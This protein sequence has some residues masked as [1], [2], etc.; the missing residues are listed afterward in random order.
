MQLVEQHVAVQRISV[1]VVAGAVFQQ[2][3]AFHAEPGRGSATLARVIG[4]GS[5]LG[6]DAICATL[7]RIGHQ[8]LELARLVATG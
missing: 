6:N 1:V 5:A 8:E 3:V 4:L 7:D 2:D